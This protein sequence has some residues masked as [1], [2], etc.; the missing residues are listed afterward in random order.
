MEITLD[1]KVI[2]KDGFPEESGEYFIV[3]A[4][5]DGT[6]QVFTCGYSAR[7]KAF[8]ASDGLA[9]AEFAIKDIVAYCKIPQARFDEL[10]N[11]EV[12]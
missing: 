6:A 2:S 3:K 5:N 1:F 4:Y 10:I 11:T 9:T 7:H 12:I 8:N